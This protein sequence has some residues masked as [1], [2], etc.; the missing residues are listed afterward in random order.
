MLSNESNDL[1]ATKDSAKLIESV[2]APQSTGCLSAIEY[3]SI[4]S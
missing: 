3:G 1:A 4:K 2:R